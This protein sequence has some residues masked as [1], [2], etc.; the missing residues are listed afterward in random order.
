[1]KRDVALEAMR[2]LATYLNFMDRGFV[3]L[4]RE[5]VGGGKK[6][7]GRIEI[8]GDRFLVDD[9][10]DIKVIAGRHLKDYEIY[11][12][13]GERNVIVVIETQGNQEGRQL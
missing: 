3:V 10:V 6:D 11:V 12:V 2:D 13:P 9:L 4:Y 8:I 1:M 5:Y 7:E